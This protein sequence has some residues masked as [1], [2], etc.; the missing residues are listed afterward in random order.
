MHPSKLRGDVMFPV[1]GFSFE[2]EPE[3]H[4]PDC[5]EQST[6]AVADAT[7][8]GER[9]NKSRNGKLHSRDQVGAPPN[10][11]E[12]WNLK[13]GGR[14]MASQSACIFKENTTRTKGLLRAWSF[15]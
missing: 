14:Q 12:C 2:N 4:R 3:P 10:L 8:S 11:R 7:S 15:L 13:S 9:V 1:E 5:I 6:A